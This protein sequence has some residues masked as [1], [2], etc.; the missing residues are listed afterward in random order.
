M[1]R[2]AEIRQKIKAWATFGPGVG[3]WL[4][5]LIIVA[6]ALISFGLGRLSAREEVRPIVPV[7]SVVGEET[8]VL[9]QG[10]PQGGEVVASR[11]GTA[12][13]YPWC[14]GASQIAEKNKVW[15]SSIEEARSAGY[16]P[17]KN[18]KGLE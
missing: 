17:A 13:H 12:Y 7:A 11:S 4:L 6:L 15:F 18:C 1:E 10:V 16:N 8:E 3:D 9:A 14:P 5:G 2:I